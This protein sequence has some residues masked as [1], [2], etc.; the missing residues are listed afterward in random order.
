MALQKRIILAALTIAAN[1]MIATVLATLL[2]TKTI[3]SS[4]TIS[5]F[6]V[7]VYSDVGCTTPVASITFDTI[8][9]GYNTIVPV[10]VKNEAV[11]GGQSMDLSMTITN[12]AS[13]P[14]YTMESVVTIVFNP[15][16]TTLAPQESTAATITL[17]ALDNAET[18][19][20][21]TFTNININIIGTEV[22]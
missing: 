4:G 11:T 6:K 12:W 10:Y 21:L 19:A 13:I 14:S 3:P 1:M 7:G 22:T 16:S 17:T 20:G 5:A 8:S 15:T 2:S 9:A 18:E